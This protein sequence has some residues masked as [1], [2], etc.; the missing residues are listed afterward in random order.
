M[1]P[2]YLHS[3]FS[4]TPKNMCVIHSF[5]NTPKQQYIINKMYIKYTK[6]TL[7]YT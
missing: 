4:G 5:I 2:F 7:K 3:N 6:Y 1:G